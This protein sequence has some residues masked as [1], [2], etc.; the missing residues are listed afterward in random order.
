MAIGSLL[1]LLAGWAWLSQF[2]PATVALHLGV[3]RF[4][5]GDIIKI[6][7]AAAGLPLGWAL[8]QRKG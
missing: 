8:L 3:T 6:L 4:I 7:L 5:I 2:M 1:I